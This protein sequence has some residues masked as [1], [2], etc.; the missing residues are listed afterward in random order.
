MIK[1]EYE[2]LDVA[3]REEFEYLWCLVKVVSLGVSRETRKERR[4]LNKSQ[5][6]GEVAK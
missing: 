5:M 1:E 6:Q 2:N 3:S 4:G